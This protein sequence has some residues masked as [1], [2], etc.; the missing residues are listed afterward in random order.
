MIKCKG[1]FLIEVTLLLNQIQ[2]DLIFP[3]F[4]KLRTNGLNFIN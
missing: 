4:D 3:S 2:G 1:T